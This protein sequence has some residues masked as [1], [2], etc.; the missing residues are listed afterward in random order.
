VPSTVTLDVDTLTLTEMSE[1]EVQSGM[2]FLAILSAGAATRRLLALWVQERRSSERPR[3][4][5]ELGSL[6]PSDAL[7]SI[8][9]S[10]PDGDPTPSDG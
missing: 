1:A 8:S 4:W 7:R 5:R 6:R 3:T 9:P 10:S 2:D